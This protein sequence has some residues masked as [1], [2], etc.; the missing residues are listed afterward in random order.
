M[1][2]YIVACG[3]AFP[4]RT[5]PNAELAVLLGV[6]P[7][8]IEANCGIRERS[9]VSAEQ[10]ASDLAAAAL[11]NALTDS[12]I[13]P[14]TIDYLIGFSLSPDYQVPGIAPS[15]QRKVPGL[16]RIPALYLQFCCARILY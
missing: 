6:S 1:T 2:C 5:V 11:R 15:I 14:E 7:E 12:K 4:E 10:S 16:R 13:D 9:W 3:E 8:W